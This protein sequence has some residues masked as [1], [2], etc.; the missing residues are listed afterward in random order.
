MGL[1]ELLLNF[2]FIIASIFFYQFFLA[3]KLQ[4]YSTQTESILIG[5]IF[6]IPAIFCLMFPYLIGENI[7]SIDMRAV[8]LILSYLYGG[9]PAGIITSILIFIPRAFIGVN[10]GL[11]AF[12][13]IEVIIF[14]VMIFILPIYRKGSSK[15]RLIYGTT[16]STLFSLLI[17]ATGLFLLQLHASDYLTDILHYYSLSILFVFFTIWGAIYFIEHHHRHMKMKQEMTEMEKMKLVSELAASIAHEIRNPMTVVRGFIQIF[18]DDDQIN[19]KYKAYFDIML[20]EL[21]RA[22]FI[23][24]DYLSLAKPQKDQEEPISVNQLVQTTIEV[25]IPFANLNSI[26][27]HSNLNDDSIIFG[28]AGKLQQCLINIYKNAI[29]AMPDGGTL[30]VTTYEKDHQA[31][32][33]ISDTGIGMTEE[34]LNRLGKPFYTTKSKGTGLGMMVCYSIISS[35]NGI[36]DVQSQKEEGTIFT[37]II[38]IHLS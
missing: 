28:N 13:L 2:L 21:D 18:K 16:L 6:C 1:E 37:I 15:Q 33:E 24:T 7:F 36:I 3:E 30:Q 23:I 5:I 29:E 31:V 27:V 8:P 17:A 4:R 9:L 10:Y 19:T 25:I 12:F 34:E 14:F 32:I 20:K 35:M 11:L 38:P 26:H 22:Q